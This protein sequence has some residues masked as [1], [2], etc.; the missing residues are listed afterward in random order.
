[1]R[2]TV[3]VPVYGVEQ[4]IAECAESLF[5]QTYPDLEYVFCDD[6]TPDRSMEVLQEV[7]VRYPERSEHVRIVRQKK[8]SGL[9]AA[10]A[11]LV[12]EIHTDYFCIVDSDD[13]LPLD[14]IE[15][16]ARRM[17]ETDADVV[18]GAYVQYDGTN[19]SAV[20]LPDHSSDADYRTKLQKQNTIEHQVWG[21]LYKSEVLEKVRPMF[22][23]GIDYCED[24]CAMVRLAAVT[25]RAWTDTVV[26]HYRVNNNTSYTNNINVKAVRSLLR[27][28]REA[29]RFFLR[30]GH[31][32]FA[33]EIGILNC[34]RECHRSGLSVAEADDVLQYFPEHLRAKLLYAMFHSSIPYTITNTLYRILRAMI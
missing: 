27:A 13:V 21:K 25:K 11:R 32:P 12:E 7:M 1:M 24:Y 4:Y 17:E 16:L 10:R 28:N 29:L 22:F 31:L 9:G 15:T 3:I 6:C 2:I 18:G 20:H 26:Y 34:Y 33:L 19:L 30:R 5:R 23:E 8:N 14:S